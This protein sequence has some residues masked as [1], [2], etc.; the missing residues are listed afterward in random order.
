MGKLTSIYNFVPLNGQVFYPSWDDN[1]QVSQDAPFSDGEDGYIDVTLHNVSPLFTRNGSADRNNPDPHSAHVMVDGKRLYFLPATSIKGMLRATLEIMSFGKMTQYTN[2]FFSK[3]ELGGKQTPDG[4]AYVELMKGVKPAWLRMEG[5][6]LFLTPCEG[7][8]LR[9]SDA[10]IASLYP[11]F[12]GKKTGYARNKAIAEDAKEWFPYYNLDGKDYRI[13]CTGDINNKTKEYIFPIGRREEVAVDDRVKESFFSVHEPS[14]DFDEITKRLKSGKEL[15][16]FY[17]PG[18]TPYDIK[19]IGISAMLRYP[20]KQSIDDVVKAQQKNLDKNKHDLAE[21]IFGYTTKGDTG[22]LR[23]RVQVGNAF[24]SKPLGDDELKT[25]VTGV[26]GQ[27]KPSFYPFYVKQTANPYKT[28]D[29][30]DGIAGRKLYRVH[31]GS[32]VT[33]LPQG[34]DNKN[35]KNKFIPI[36]ENQTFRL[37]IAVHNLR[38]METG[39]LLSAITL[40]KTKGVWH[41]IGLARGYGYGKLEIDDIRL[42]SGF[43][44]SI[45]EYLKEFERQMSIFTYSELSSKVMWTNTEQMAMLVGILGEHDDDD[46]RVMEINSEVYG[47]EYLEAKRN[48][49]KLAEKTVPIYTFLSES[50]KKEIKAASV[51]YRKN[52]DA[53]KRK[54][55]KQQWVASHKASY[56]EAQALFA[57][58]HYDEACAKYG[59]LA[60]ELQIADLDTTQEETL[61]HKVR[62]AQNA[63]LERKQ[64]EVLALQQQALQQKLEAGLGAELEAKWAEGTPKAGQYKVADFKVMNNKTDQWMKKAKETALTNEEKEAY[65]ATFR[66]LSQPG[67]HPKKEDKELTVKNSKLW[68][69]AQNKLGDRFDGLIGELYNKLTR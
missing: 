41:N 25:E 49:D 57:S 40:H 26:L 67:S 63:E 37:R 18:K 16:V 58:G 46:M 9:F 13:V 4:K 30:A 56:E 24:A 5:E 44:F 11:S 66:R 52:L 8:G 34:N 6:K 35:Y 55:R 32:T 50:E 68:Q 7:D 64:Q 48:F 36:P 61:M 27:P 60:R 15:A 54:E 19:A 51:A 31:R 10:K 47:Q 14:P 21:V 33:E 23:G 20:Y 39:A 2:R 43:S 62:E 1:D 12:R 29:N 45:D 22:S 3:R 69:K 65:A 53:Q 17:L 42:S 28:Y 38:K 59:A